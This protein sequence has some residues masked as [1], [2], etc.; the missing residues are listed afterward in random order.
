M[1]SHRA[2]RWAFDERYAEMLVEEGYRVD[3]SVTPLVSWKTTL[4]DPSGRGGSDY[5]E[6]PHESYWVDLDDISRRGTSD[7]LEVPV[8]IVSFRSSLPID[9]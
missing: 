7:L 2:G 4:G 5:S 3:C 1:V 6:F 9:R 8:T